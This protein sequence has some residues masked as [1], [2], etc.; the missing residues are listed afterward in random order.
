MP[1][2]ERVDEFVQTVVGGR[3]VEA[4]RDFYHENAS[5][6]EN[7][8]PPREGREALIEYEKKSLQRIDGIETQLASAF[9]VDGDRVVIHW[10]F[11]A[12]DKKGVRRQ[13]EELTL[14]NWVGD[15]ILVERFFYDSAKAWLPLETSSAE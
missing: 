6:Q 3:H 13:L 4:I 12:T 10:V 2:N 8:N 5:M 15:R 11:V 1:T 7:D 9:L 14:Q